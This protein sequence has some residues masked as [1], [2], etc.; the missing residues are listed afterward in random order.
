MQFKVIDRGSPDKKNGIIC[1]QAIELTTPASKQKYPGPLRRI[2]Y[3]DAETRKTLTFITNNF[4]LTALKVAALYK[5]SWG[6][7][8]FFYVKLKIMQSS[9]FL[10]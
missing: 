4:K 7:E 5:Y 8:T 10:N 1:D 6:I 3:Y 9:I 2:R